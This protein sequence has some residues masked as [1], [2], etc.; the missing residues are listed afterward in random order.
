[1]ISDSINTTSF[2]IPVHNNYKKNNKKYTRK[3]RRTIYS[4]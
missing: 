2:I 3:I 1:M 4:K